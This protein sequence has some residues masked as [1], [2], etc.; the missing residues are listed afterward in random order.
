M[1][2]HHFPQHQKLPILV[3]LHQETS[4]TGRVGKILEARGFKLD[5]RRPVLG[6]P[7][8]QTLAHHHGVIIFGGPMSA[9]D[10]ENYIKQEIDFCGQALREDKPFL[11]I[12][13]GAQM[14]VK[15]CGGRVAG[16][17]CGGVEIGWYPLRATETGQK[18]MQ[19]PEMVYHFHREGFDLPSGFEL[20]ATADLYPN[21]AYRVGNNAWG[22]QFHGEL[23]EVM[24]RRWA[25]KGAHRFDLPNAQKGHDHL[26][27]RLLYDSQLRIW[28]ETF[29]GVV[30]GENTHSKSAPVSP[31]A[32]RWK[33]E[34]AAAIKSFN[35]WAENNELPLREYRDF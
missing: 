26:Q 35:E 8:P 32:A 2:S 11:G 14:L 19:W 6:D 24:M 16:A 18:L 34:N 7:L 27:G 29:L 3:L 22:V 15:Q 23:T 21:Q 10:D 13:L 4:S 12:C 25:V 17:P 28:M 9:N 30:F 31:A 20:L 1:M 5:I 33:H